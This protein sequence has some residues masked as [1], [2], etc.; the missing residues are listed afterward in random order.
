M[1][2]VYVYMNI[3]KSL[4]RDILYIYLVTFIIIL[5]PFNIYNL[6][7]LSFG[8]GTPGGEKGGGE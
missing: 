4:M 6:R 8:E 1:V 5:P 7:L 3:Y 2:Y